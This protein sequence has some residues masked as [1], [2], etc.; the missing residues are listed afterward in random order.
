MR[1]VIVED[2]QLKIKVLQ[3]YAARLTKVNLVHSFVHPLEALDWLRTNQV[4]GLILDNN[5]PY[6]NGQSFVERMPYP[7]ATILAL[8]TEEIP[9]AFH[10][11]N[12][13]GH[14]IKPYSFYKFI[15][16]VTGIEKSLK[17]L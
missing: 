11:T 12:I 15:Q 4:D 13:V 3:S 5:M 6:L 2:E 7:I 16:A 8:T 14:L 9:I 10:Q 1:L 17:Q